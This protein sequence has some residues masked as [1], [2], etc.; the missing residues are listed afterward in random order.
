MSG[1]SPSP[2]SAALVTGASSGLGVEIARCLA[3]RGHNVILVAR[4]LDRLEEMAAELADAHGVTAEAIPCDLADAEARESLVELIEE[5]GLA[6]DVLVNNAGLG[7]NGPFHEQDGARQR[8]IV[9]VNVDALVDLCTRFVPSMVARGAGGVLNV[10][11]TTGFQPLPGTITYAATKAFVLSFTEGLH[12]ELSGTG[13]HATALCPGPVKTEIWDGAEA[14]DVIEMAPSFV[15]TEAD[16]VAED[17]VKGL[18]R[19][20]RVVVPGLANRIGALNGQYTPRSI[21]LPVA[22]ALSRFARR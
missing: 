19:N 7:S 11:S 13:V 21:L 22:D 4:R 14:G 5:T 15:W 18:E 17:G 20:R 16:R 8:T 9:E 2:S 3:R 1:P 6:V 10:G 12:T